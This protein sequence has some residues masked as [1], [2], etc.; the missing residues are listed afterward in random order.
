MRYKV[1]MLTLADFKT[2]GGVIKVRDGDRWLLA[3]AGQSLAYA[4]LVADA[5]REACAKIAEGWRTNAPSWEPQGG[6]IAEAIRNRNN[7]SQ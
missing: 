2:D 6:Y 1:I 3:N 7:S 5:E 4:L